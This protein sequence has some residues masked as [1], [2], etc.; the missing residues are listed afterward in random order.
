[1]SWLDDKYDDKAGVNRA[2]EHQR[3]IEAAAAL[4]A[5]NSF[6]RQPQATNFRDT[7]AHST[8]GLSTFK[9]RAL[10]AFLLVTGAALGLGANALTADAQGRTF[11][12]QVLQDANRACG[13][14]LNQVKTPLTPHG[15]TNRSRCF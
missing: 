11:A 5:G 1:M 13:E 8:S 6:Q 9:G 4:R 14:V 7:T 10:G 12:G 15:V 3:R 2:A